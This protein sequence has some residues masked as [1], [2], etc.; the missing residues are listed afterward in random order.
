MT[1][2]RMKGRCPL[3]FGKQVFPGVDAEADP[4]PDGLEY[5]REPYTFTAEIA[6]K[7]EDFLIGIGAIEVVERHE[8]PEPVAF[9][10]EPDDY[11]AADSEE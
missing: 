11:E 2:Y 3:V 5:K 8:V 6:E 7:L 9:V 1:T 4:R 10:P